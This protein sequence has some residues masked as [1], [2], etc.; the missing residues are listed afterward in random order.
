MAQRH[1]LHALDAD[2]VRPVG[3]VP[4]G[5]DWPRHLVVDGEFVHVAN[6]LSNAQF[7]AVTSFG[8]SRIVAFGSGS[9]GAIPLPSFGGVAVTNVKITEQTGYLVVGG[10]VE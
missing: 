4:S 6:Q 2:A 10:S 1:T 5:G 9:L 8:L 3:W 7:E